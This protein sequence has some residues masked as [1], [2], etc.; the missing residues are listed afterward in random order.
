MYF[1]VAWGVVANSVRIESVFE[2][3]SDHSPIIATIGPQVFHRVVPTTLVTHNTDWNVFRVY[4][5]DHINFNSR[6]KQYSELNDE[7]H[8]FTNILQEAAWHSTHTLRRL[9]GR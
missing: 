1:F 3:S 4:I 5:S 6:I 8:Y 7:T 9:W 2:L